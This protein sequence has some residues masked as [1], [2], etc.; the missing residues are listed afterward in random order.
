MPKSDSPSLPEE[1]SARAT[2]A[3][4]RGPGLR[5]RA[6]RAQSGLVNIAKLVSGNRFTQ[7]YRTNYDLVQ[8]NHLY[9]LRHY[10]PTQPPAPSEASRG[11]GGAAPAAAVSTVLLVP[12]LMV[13]AEV[14]DIAPELSL[15]LWL[16]SRGH[17][18]WLVDFGIPGQPSPQAGS[19]EPIYEKDLVDHILATS[20]AI[21]EVVARSGADVHLIG[22]SQGGMFAYQTAAYR[23]CKGVASVIT[24]G[25][26]VDFLSNLPGGVHRGIWSNMFQVGAD[27]I[28]RSAAR[29]P[30]VSGRLSS[31][32]FK[33]ISPRQELKHFTEMLRFLDDEEELKRIEPARRFLGGEGFIPWPGP[34]LRAFVEEFVVHNRLMTGGL[35]IAG[36]T[37]SLSDLTVPVLY[38][39]GARDQV[40]REGSVRAIEKVLPHEA[41]RGVVVDTGHLGLVVGT[42]ARSEVFP[43]VDDWLRALAQ[44][45]TPALMSETSTAIS[46]PGPAGA[47][48]KPVVQAMARA[49]WLQ[50][51]KVGLS[52]SGTARWSRWQV[53]HL[54]E[55][56]RFWDSAPLSLGRLLDEQARALPN[57]TLLLWEDRAYSYAEANARVSHIAAALY[58]A[59]LRPGQPVGLLMDNHPDC[60]TGLAAISRLGGVAV[61]LNPALR[62]AAFAH[63]LRVT[64]VAD[65]LV[66]PPSHAHPEL[67]PDGPTAE[68]AERRPLRRLLLGTSRPDPTAP[69]L[70]QPGDIDL[71]S[72]DGSWP[73]GLKRNPACAADIACLMFTSGTT[74]KPKAARITNRRFLFAAT[75]AS[76]GCALTPTDT[77]YCC[78]PLH[79]ATG[80]ILAAGGALVAGSRLALAPRFSSRRFWPDVRRSGATVVFYVGELCRYLVSAPP[81]PL[82]KSHAVRLFVGNGMRADVWRQL[83]VRCGPVSV[84][85]FYGATEGNG[86]LVNLTGEKVGSVGRVPFGLVDTLL[87]EYDPIGESFRR[88]ARGLIV[89]ALSGQPGMLLVEIAA[90][91]PLSRFD[92]YTDEGAT[93]AKILR[94][95]RRPGDSWFISGDLLREDADGDYWFVDRVG[96]TFRWKG[97]N[98]STE[99]VAAVLSQL[100][101][102]AMCAVY[103]VR[104]PGHEGRAGM[105]AL[106]LR[107]GAELDPRACF[108]LV[109]Q[110]LIAA[111]QPR[112][113]RIVS[114]LP[115]TETLK[116][117]KQA[118]ID[119]GIDLVRTGPLYVHD[120]KQRTYVRVSQ[121]QELVTDP[122]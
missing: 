52:L 18:V 122:L 112:F 78:L 63:A 44:Q 87:A 51:G 115:T 84:L 116:V 68:S 16:C 82:E 30:Q 2:A 48:L 17:D 20:S 42:R 5:Q 120:A 74:G 70:A 13:T 56:A 76:A 86:L 75:A 1:S 24:M 109:A 11:A 21:D 39:L 90:N 96:D 93:Q 41:C 100:P 47:A 106:V 69:K 114:E 14:Y 59:G 61:L 49:L 25:S 79:H 105:A 64:G 98:V 26:P 3:A 45:Q 104:V 113:L 111:A 89:P 28:R 118:L 95:V 27:S 73:A 121:P 101:A 53:P 50:L 77:V 66:A 62:G 46:K 108:E 31:L 55:L 43:R 7:P 94:D 117:K 83:L 91:N 15:V 97:E 85:E 12:P 60:L 35:V 37:A 10:Q 81:S 23:R 22:Y 58:H 92:G 72:L 102:V 8:S 103:G 34:A 9:C 6:R 54:A 119:D 57:Q 88:D 36:R 33:I 19:D 65:V 71:E 80:L 99:Q 40:A 110:H 29:L 32:A 67:L 107:P 4:S 38:F